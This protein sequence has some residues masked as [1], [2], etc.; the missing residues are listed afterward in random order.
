MDVW[1]GVGLVCCGCLGHGRYVAG[2]RQ[3]LCSHLSS[4]HRSRPWGNE[5]LVAGACSLLDE[6]VVPLPV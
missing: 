4:L 2:H 1:P 5:V 3:L 6:K